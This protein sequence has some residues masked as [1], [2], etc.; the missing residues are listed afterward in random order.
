MVLAYG[1]IRATYT[2]DGERGGVYSRRNFL[3]KERIFSR[4]IGDSI[5]RRVRGYD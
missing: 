3:P 1:E 2:A 5:Y 4:K